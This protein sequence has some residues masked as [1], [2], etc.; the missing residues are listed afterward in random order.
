MT[1]KHIDFDEGY[2]SLIQSMNK[3]VQ[4]KS[5][6]GRKTTKFKVPDFMLDLLGTWKKAQKEELLQKGRSFTD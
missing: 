3:F 5:T 6:K 4:L 2:I 1:R